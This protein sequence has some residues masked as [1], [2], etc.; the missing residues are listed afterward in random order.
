[1]S[2]IA[3]S[4]YSND[5]NNRYLVGEK[6]E[7]SG[8][9]DKAKEIYEELYKRNSSNQQYFNAL[10]R[11]YVLLKQYDSSVKLLEQKLSTIPQ[12]INLY[13]LLGS[14]Y[15][16]MGN[17]T[18]AY[19]MWEEGLSK[20]PQSQFNYQ[21]MANY[22]IE[23]RDFEKA[24]DFLKRGKKISDNPLIFSYDL[25]NL[26]SLT[27]RF[28]DAAE[29]Y[30]SILLK[31]PEQYQG[32]Q[33]RLLSYI[34]KV[35]ALQTTI[36]VFE[37]KRDDD[38]INMSKLLASLY[39]Q[40]RTYEKAYGIYS[41]IDSK[42]KSNGIELFNFA[43]ILYNEHQFE[44]GAKVFKDIIKRYPSSPVIPS[45]KLG[46][47]ETLEANL[48]NERESETNWKPYSFNKTG[49]PQIVN[50]II[51][52]YSE[53]VKMYPQTEPANEALL[54]IGILKINRLND[55]EGAR[56]TFTKLTGTNSKFAIKSYE[57]MG[58]IYLQEGDLEKS[59]EM[60]QKLIQNNNIP[61]E[62]KN[63]A[64]YKDAKIWFYEGNFAA[65]R[66]LLN[67]IIGSYKD[68]NSNDAL[69]LS[70]LLNTTVNDSSNLIIFANAELLT[71]QRKF[72]QARE[73][74]M[75]ISQNPQAFALQSLAK[76]RVAEMDIALDNYDSSMKVLQE[77]ADEKEKNIYSDKALYLQGNIY[78]FAKKDNP[79]AIETYES[80]LIKFPNSIYLDDAREA[81]NK[82]KNKIS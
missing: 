58:N 26:Y 50:E 25:A 56:E 75:I 44:L 9:P 3:L 39:I 35:D 2:G 77:I 21:V 68:N 18:K 28:K 71:E 70:L 47:A 69:E 20:Q 11:I 22:A 62:E 52:T 57:E 59:K 6:Y 19:S 15:Y 65:G 48:N 4:Q 33:N 34:G 13:G 43:Q 79:K 40:E 27:M 67:K 7:Q 32:V 1:M 72:S 60:F 63:Y 10:N 51:A 49:D 66:E 82:L 16:L 73:K 36:D 14:T 38:N 17:E 30:L 61:E 54:R 74:Y 5:D 42:S 45:A 76:L 78:Q 31:N 23:R 12:D 46:Y 24:I 37:K 29:E 80:L 8:Y 81:I 53:I 41:E 55:L 64:R